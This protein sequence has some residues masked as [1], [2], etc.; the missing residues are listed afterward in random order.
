MGGRV[1]A[2]PAATQQQLDACRREATRETTPQNV[3]A[4][5]EVLVQA[6]GAIGYAGDAMIRGLLDH[7]AAQGLPFEASGDSGPLMPG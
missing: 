7:L 3:A 6:S 2:Q 5:R 1:F 4:P